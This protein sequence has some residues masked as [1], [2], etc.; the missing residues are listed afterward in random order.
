MAWLASWLVCCLAALLTG[1]LA[2]CLAGWPDWSACLA[3]WSTGLLLSRWIVHWLAAFLVCCLASLPPGCPTYWLTGLLPG[4]PGLLALLAGLADWS[5]GLLPVS[6]ARKLA[7]LPS[8][9][10][11]LLA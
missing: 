11:Y 8:C 6:L 9:L 7:G 1:S 10:A 4:W 3:D 2:C 5:N